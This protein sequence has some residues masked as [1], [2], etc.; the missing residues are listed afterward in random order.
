M[1]NDA[2]IKAAKPGPKDY[3]LGDAEQLYLLVT[4]AGGKHWRMNYTYGPKGAR[5]QKTLSFGSYPAITLLAARAKRDS[6]KAMLRDG[7]DPAVERR[8]SD[9]A[10]AVANANT[11]RV[12]GDKWF[13]L[14][15]G[16]SLEKL[17]VW[18]AGHGGKWKIT[19][20]HHWKGQHRAGLW[21]TV[22][23]RDVLRSLRNDIY[24]EIGDMPIAS[25]KAP[26]LLALLAGIQA[27][28]SVET[29]HRTRQRISQI[30]VYGMAALGIADADPA[31]SLG[32]ALIPKPPAKK[33]PSI[34]DGCRT[35]KDQVTAIRQVLIDCEGIRGRAITKLAMRFIALT[36]VRPNELRN[37]RWDELED[38]DGPEPIW[39]I[40]ALRM[41]GDD[42]R[43]SEV[44]GDH[45]VPLASQSLDVLRV[46]RP[47]T[48][49]LPLLFPS[50]RHLH[51][52]ISENTLRAMLIR[53]GYYQRHVP[54]GFRA[55]FSTIMN[56]RSKLAGI[57]DDRPTIDLMLAHVPKNKVE[58]AYNRAAFMPRRRELAQDWADLLTADMWPLEVHMGQPI[59]WT[60]AL[61]DQPRG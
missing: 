19:D 57:A 44:E 1:L 4:R 10:Q 20:V 51:R 47:L 61:P 30:F 17:D 25:I 8:K 28:G 50:E 59:R 15:S 24:P 58:M 13:E 26:Q 36:A 31:A 18:A 5:E 42:E 43:K 38:L 35:Y 56:E 53:A 23:C 46:L 16:W 22:H 40:P 29:A 27:R 41:K 33:Q 48:G 45:L 54:H 34:I 60:G 49:D 37:A 6:A 12:V 14:W 39:R 11:F 2:K 7:R 55:A 3:K 9:A 32:K 21:A 52:P